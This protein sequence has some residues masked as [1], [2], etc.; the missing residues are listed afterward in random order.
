MARR[1]N[2]RRWLG[3]IGVLAGLL[4]LQAAAARAQDIKPG[5]SY[6]GMVAA[7]GTVG[8]A[9]TLRGLVITGDLDRAKD[10]VQADDNSCAVGSVRFIAQE[11]VG[12]TKTDAKGNAWKIVKIALPAAEA[13]LVT[14]ADMVVGDNT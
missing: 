6:E 2:S 5:K 3:A 10:Y 7:C 12:E 8:E 14:T 4:M 9:E 11:Q 1:S 13:Y